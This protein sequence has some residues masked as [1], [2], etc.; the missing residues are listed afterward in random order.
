MS[1]ESWDCHAHVIGDLIR[2]PPSP[3]SSYDPPNAL[4]SNYL[5]FLDQMSVE[6]GV[7]VQPSIYG[8][9]RTCLLDAL[10]KSNGRLCGVAVPAIDTTTDEL[11]RWHLSLR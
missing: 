6:R 9:D 1:V 10:G 4:L 2:Y 3:L 11:K 8:H 7:L 5:S